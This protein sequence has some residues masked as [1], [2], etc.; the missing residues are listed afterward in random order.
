MEGI[1]KATKLNEAD[2]IRALL[3]S[4]FIVDYGYINKVNPDKTVNVT[5]A[6]KPVTTDGK[7]LPET[8]TDNVEVLTISGA[9]FSIQWD[10]KAK[11]KVLLLG[12]KDYTPKVGSVEMAEVPKAF[13]HYTRSNLK[14][15]PLCIFNDDAKVKLAIEEGKLTLTTEDEMSVT[16][17]KALT[18]KAE[19]GQASIEASEAVSVKAGKGLKIEAGEDTE[20]KAGSGKKIKLNGDSKQFV[21][22]AE[23]NQALTTFLTQLTVALTTTPIAGNGAPQPT[24][25]SLPTS[26]DISAAKTQTVVTGG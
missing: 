10:Y 23:L 9:G 1:I 4:Y 16:S 19:D 13:I 24:W 7:E 12:L 2:I 8:T 20:I 11:D 21:T 26:I 3:N 14:A 17:G 15:I 5:H 25:T 22:W 6:A 18:I